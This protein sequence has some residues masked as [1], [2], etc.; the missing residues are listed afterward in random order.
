MRTAVTRHIRQS[1]SG[2]DWEDTW[3]M[4]TVFQCCWNLG[5][6]CGCDHHSIL[7]TAGEMRSSYECYT[8]H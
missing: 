3:N 8:L 6:I 5:T 7:W 4:S 2:R 1:T